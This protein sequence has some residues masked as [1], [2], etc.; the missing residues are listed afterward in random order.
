MNSIG[1]TVNW[2]IFQKATCQYKAKSKDVSILTNDPTHRKTV[3]R[4]LFNRNKRDRDKNY[5]YRITC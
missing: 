2:N 3:L 5:Y 1:S 4:R